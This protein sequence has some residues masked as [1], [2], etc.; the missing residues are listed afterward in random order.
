MKIYIYI[1]IALVTLN[2]TIMK[3]QSVSYTYVHNDPYDYK[4]FSLS[5]DPLFID[6]NGHNGYAYGWGL[7]AEHM[8]GKRL[9]AN[10][11]MRTGFGTNLYRKSNKNSRNYFNM[12]GGLG[13]IFVNK[14]RSR[15][16]PIILSQS[17][18]TS[19]NTR[20][21]TTTKI[22]GGVPAKCWLIVALRGG[23]QQY[24]N[25][26]DY[27]N[28]ADT[29]LNFNGVNYKTAKADN[30]VFKDTVNKVDLLQV[31]GI[32]L[33]SI[34]AGIQFRS[35]RNMLID[36]DG[37]GYRGSERYSDFYIDVL[38]APVIALRD[39]SNPSGTKYDVKYDE[40]SHFGWRFGYFLRK[41]KDQGFSLKFELGSRPGFKAPSN[42]SVPVN[43]KNLYFTMSYGLYIPLK[44]KPIYEGE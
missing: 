30:V 20:T 37:Y 15:N 5:I 7:R 6:V 36:V 41:P 43:V 40:V 13:L 21:T 18:S 24:T 32:A 34:Y 23:L 38:F 2:V 9:L 12:E 17:S 19:G 35:I 31:G 1:I 10:F 8:M 42:T 28:L 11:D 29:L 4:N 39:Y 3:S 33:T 44:L 27:K 25:T 16:V 14:V 22:S 26:L